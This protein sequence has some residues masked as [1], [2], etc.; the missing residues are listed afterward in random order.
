[1]HFGEQNENDHGSNNTECNKSVSMQR[2]ITP[3]SGLVNNIVVAKFGVTTVFCSF[4]KYKNIQVNS[5]M[6][7][8][9]CVGTGTV[10]ITRRIR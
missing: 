5:T 6:E 3:R 2:K 8:G 9:C 7:M 4:D 1:V 10:W